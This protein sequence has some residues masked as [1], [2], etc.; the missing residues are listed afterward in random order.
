MLTAEYRTLPQGWQC[1]ACGTVY[2]PTVTACTSTHAPPGVLIAA[3]PITAWN[4]TPP[5]PPF[6]VAHAPSLT[7]SAAQNET[8]DE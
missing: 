3:N 4:D 5:I 1:P 6:V 2:A 8:G 7:A